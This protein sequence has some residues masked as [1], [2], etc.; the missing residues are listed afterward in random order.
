M[1]INRAIKRN[2]FALYVLNS[3]DFYSAFDFERL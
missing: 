3:L 2:L 1:L